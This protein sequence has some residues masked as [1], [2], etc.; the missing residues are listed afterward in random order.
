[1]SDPA[2]DPDVVTSATPTRR[3]IGD[4]LRVVLVVAALALGAAAIGRD[5]DGFLDAVGR[6]GVGRVA[7]ATVLT[8]AGTL[9]SSEV[10]R[11]SVTSVAGPL[12]VPAAVRIFAATQLGK[13]LPGA[14]WTVVGQIDAA[15][16]HGLSRS[17]VGVGA[18]LFLAYH[19]TSG[20]IVAALLLPWTAPELVA[21]YP[22]VF[23][24]GPLLL[25]ALVPAVLTRIVGIGLRV[26]RQPPLPHPLRWR[27]VAA[28]ALWMVVVWACFGLGVV[29]VSAPLIAT[30]PDVS[31]LAAATGGFAIAWV[32][33][34]LVL[35][36]PAGIG[37]REVVLG[38]LLAPL[39]GATGATS[40][41]VIVR[42]IHTGVD[43]ALPLATGWRGRRATEDTDTGTGTG[44]GTEVAR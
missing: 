44:T 29:V 8:A 10:W 24:L 32:I 31:L 17:R 43:L 3:R 18:L 20:V 40:V 6:I 13:Y 33:G 42:V 23:A 14:V 21:A 36:A 5:L 37:A 16:R 25:V 9:A 4:A 11:R 30:G 22:W 19:A 34:L 27:D 38:V 7:V 2:A 28:P 1:M 26:L 12:S 41:A 35:P 15:K 39:M